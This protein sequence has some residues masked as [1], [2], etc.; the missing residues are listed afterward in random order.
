[1][2][3]CKD[4]RHYQNQLPKITC[5]L[6]K[7]FRHHLLDRGYQPKDIDPI[8]LAAAHQLP[9]DKIPPDRSPQRSPEK[10]L[11]LHLTY[12]L[13]VPKKK[14]QHLLHQECQHHFVNESTNTTQRTTVYSGC[15][16]DVHEHPHTGGSTSYLELA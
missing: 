10:L 5:A 2:I 14:I 13:D 12:A 11:A 1:M 8:F 3:N 16:N 4:T 6:Q 7:N 9:S 15:S